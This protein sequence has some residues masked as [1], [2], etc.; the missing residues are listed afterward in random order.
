MYFRLTPNEKMKFLELF[1]VADP[2]ACYRRRESV[3]PQQALALMNSA[4]ALDQGRT[5]AEKL[6]KETGDRDEEPIN[7][8]F[9]AAAFEQVLSR[10]PTADEK[11]VCL[12]F[13][14]ENA[15]LVP[16]LGQ[17]AFPAGGEAKRP[18]ATQPHLRAREN[19]VH[20]LFSHNDFVTVR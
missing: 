6:T 12:Q 17:T 7:A 3:V 1:D 10:F 13:L 19:L 2:N 20:V 16:S 14:V 18:P 11:K 5:L 9:I 8:A 4:L 15:K